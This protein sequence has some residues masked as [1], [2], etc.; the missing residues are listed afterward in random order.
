LLV[1]PTIVLSTVVGT[2]IFSAIGQSVEQWHQILVGGLSIAAAVLASL[3][4]FMSYSERAEKHRL[5]AARY[6]AI[7]R[8]L[9]ITR[10]APD[11]GALEAL[12]D[13]RKSIDVLATESPNP[14]IRICSKAWK[15]WEQ[16][17]KTEAR[18]A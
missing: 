8:Q 12:E 15:N 5:A 11:E 16:W 17:N 4:T 13:L 1:I 2:S 9:D 7:C 6:G 10:I 18:G 3:Q 14:P